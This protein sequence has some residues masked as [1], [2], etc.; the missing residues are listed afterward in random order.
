M[1][2]CLRLTSLSSVVPGCGVGG[3]YLLVIL[4]SLNPFFPCPLLR[5]TTISF[6]EEMI[7]LSF[8]TIIQFAIPIAMKFVQHG[9]QRTGGYGTNF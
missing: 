4:A 3:L 9:V 6:P 2:I 7:A 8:K 1:E 5:T